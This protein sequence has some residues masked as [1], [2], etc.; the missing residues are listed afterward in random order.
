MGKVLTEAQIMAKKIRSAA[1]RAERRR[2][3]Q[4]G[5]SAGNAIADAEDRSRRLNE[6]IKLGKNFVR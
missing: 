4:L 6:A 5:L 1:L 3:V 2:L